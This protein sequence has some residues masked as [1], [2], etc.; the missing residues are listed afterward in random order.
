MP[1][2]IACKDLSTRRNLGNNT[3]VGPSLTN[4]A[5]DKR[6]GR[7]LTP[8]LQTQQQHGKD[9]F[10][11]YFPLWEQH[12]GGYESHT[13]LRNTVLYSPCGGSSYFVWDDERSLFLCTMFG[14]V[15]I[16][17][18]GCVIVFEFRC[19]DAYIHRTTLQ[20]HKEYQ[21]ISKLSELITTPTGPD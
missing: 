4:N 11:Q 1:G 15:H 6:S 9:S 5:K 18:T 10:S 8:H 14:H 21:L 13:D 12:H 17:T 19:F 20:I 3:N 2:L 7:P 16:Y